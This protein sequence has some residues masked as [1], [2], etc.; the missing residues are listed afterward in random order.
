VRVTVVVAGVVDVVLVAAA[1]VEAVVAGDVVGL[2][3]FEEAG[4][5][6]SRWEARFGG[7]RSS[8]STLSSLI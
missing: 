8:A 5:S 1:V 4:A 7:G 3:I 2:K 6:S